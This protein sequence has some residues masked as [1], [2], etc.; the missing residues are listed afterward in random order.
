MLGTGCACGLLANVALAG[1]LCELAA[2][3]AAAGVRVGVPAAALRL[4]TSASAAA[5][6]A[7]GQH[8]CLYDLACERGVLVTALAGVLCKVV[9]EVVRWGAPVAA[10]RWVPSASAAAQRARTASLCRGSAGELGLRV[11]D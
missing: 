11:Q 2:V 5:L 9:A 3:L 8:K 1:V 7:R 6:H 10:P 4:V